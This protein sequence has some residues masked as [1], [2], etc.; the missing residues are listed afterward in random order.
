M[1]CTPRHLKP[2]LGAPRAAAAFALLLAA[3]GDGSEDPGGRSSEGDDGRTIA[4]DGVQWSTTAGAPFD[5]VA[6]S[7]IPEAIDIPMVEVRT[8]PGFGYMTRLFPSDDEHAELPL[9]IYIDE[10]GVGAGEA[11]ISLIGEGVRC[12][13]VT[14]AIAPLP[15]APADTLTRLAGA[16]EGV[17]AG[18]H[19][20]LGLEE[21][22]LA[23]RAFDAM[24]PELIPLAAAEHYVARLDDGRSLRDALDELEPEAKNTVAR[25]VAAAGLVDYVEDMEAAIQSSGFITEVAVDDVGKRRLPGKQAGSGTSCL[26]LGLG[27][28]DYIDLGTD[29][30][31]LV[32]LLKTQREVSISNATKNQVLSDMVAVFSLVLAIPSSGASLALGTSLLGAQLYDDFRQGMYPSDI[33][34]ELFTFEV[35]S[36]FNEDHQTVAN[37]PQWDNA[38]IYARSKGWNITSAAIDLVLNFGNVPGSKWVGNKAF[39]KASYTDEFR[40]QFRGQVDNLGKEGIAEAKKALPPGNCF[41]LDGRTYGPFDVT[42]P[43]YTES[44]VIGSSIRL[45]DHQRFDLIDLGPAEIELELDETKFLQGIKQRNPVQVRKKSLSITPQP[46]RVATAGEHIT[47]DV[48]VDYA[49]YADSAYVDFRVAPAS[50][51]IVRQTELAPGLFE[52]EIATPKK[53]TSFPV[54]LFAESLSKSLPEGA[55]AR[56]AQAE[57]EIGATLTL[58]PDPGCVPKGELVSFSA[59]V[60]PDTESEILWFE[61]SGS[62]RGSGKHVSYQAPSV[63]TQVTVRARLASDPDVQ[64]EVTFRVGE[65]AEVAVVHAHAAGVSFPGSSVCGGSGPDYD[66]DRQDQ[67]IEDFEPPPARPGPGARSAGQRHRALWSM[68]GLHTMQFTQLR[69]E[70]CASASFESTVDFDADYAIDDTGHR[71]DVDFGMTATSQCRN[72]PERGEVCSTAGGGGAIV[73]TYYLEISEPTSYE[74]V[75]ELDCGGSTPPFPT[76]PAQ[77]QANMGRFI[78]GGGGPESMTLP[79][80]FTQDPDL[81]IEPLVLSSACNDDASRLRVRRRFDLVGPLGDASRDLVTL[82]VQLSQATYGNLGSAGGGGLGTRTTRHFMRGFVELAPVD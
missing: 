9:P 29:T 45:E 48:S 7:G 51:S 20:M 28:R 52:V 22:A 62:I 37:Q 40:A 4:C 60:E 49:D 34:P 59:I 64:D 77:V 16:L 75:L 79:N 25:V 74:L 19:A 17:R 67:T 14:V 72:V 21:G 1:R 58:T 63:S 13:P 44:R 69:S 15:E 26:P 3:C 24:A 54:Y 27:D 76:G 6:I 47:L 65:C 18:Y 38:K 32:A 43:A 8:A 39:P 55:P 56:K 81:F 33:P 41:R 57:I 31:K 70:G 53:E 78:G 23:D 30:E 80:G 2:S 82:T 68:G 71:V 5:R 61:T 35:E 73:A 36:A 50:A 12:P 42:E 66:E 10:G 11:Q 46:A